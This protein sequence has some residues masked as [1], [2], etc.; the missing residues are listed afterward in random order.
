MT[1]S[2]KTSEMLDHLWM[3]FSQM[4]QFKDEGSL[5]IAETGKGCWITDNRGNRIFDLMSGMWLKAVGYGREEI[6]QAVFEAMKKI[7]FNPWGM[8]SEYTMRLSA[9][10]A[11][12]APD[13][14]SRVFLV[15][16]GSEANETALKMAKKYHAIRKE[17]GRY[18]VVS[19]RGS[20]HGNT[21]A[22]MALGGGG[23]AIPWDYGPLQP[24]NFHG[25]QP[26][27]FHCAFCKGRNE[28]SLECADEVERAIIA[29]G[30]K[31]VA[32]LIGEPISISAGVVPPHPEYWP[33][34]RN[35]C[36]KYGV[37]L[38]LDEVVTGFGRTGRW[39]ASEHWDIQPDITTV[40]KALSSGYLPI[41][42]A[43]A[44]KKVADTFLG[45]ENETFKHLLTYSGHPICSA[46]ALANLE[47][48]ENENLVAN[49]AN[50]G[51]YLYERLQAL[52]HHR[53]IGDVRGGYGLLCGVELVRDKRTNEH[54]PKE[55]KI[56]AK[57]DAIML[58]RGL[59]TRV[60]DVIPL[61]PPLIVTKNEI[62]HI[63]DTLDASL[64]ELEK[65]V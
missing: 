29:E 26:F 50:M 12:L 22:T 19:R 1:E 17:P 58:K 38:I 11:S 47:I 61:V 25:P 14:Q 51:A 16:G 45:S 3:P 20:Y 52:A 37:L 59:M 7:T 30:P 34:I 43:I 15:S 48:I 65:E 13:K 39:F 32:A 42:A 18:K 57:L 23:V 54:F 28:C 2:A 36:D 10:L 60:S 63:V 4:A 21:H 46:A 44:S 6:G 41:G 27:K 5:R 31:T 49:S 53:V 8:T 9:K 62:D 33:R 40:A 56:P 24:G 64:T 55:A 35:I